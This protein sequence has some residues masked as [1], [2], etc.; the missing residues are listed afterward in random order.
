MAPTSFKIGYRRTGYL[1][2][3]VAILLNSGCLL[4]AAGAAGGAAATYSYCKGK[5]AEAYPASFED[6]CQAT[7][8]ALLELGMPVLDEKHKDTEGHIDSKTSDGDRVRITVESIQ[9]RIPAEGTLTR[10]SVRVATFGDHL[11]SDR[12]LQQVNLHLMPA[13]P[14]AQTAKGAAMP[15]SPIQQTGATQSAPPPQ[16]AQPLPASDGR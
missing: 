11:V 4:I 9:S 5:V 2:L 15:T 16:S 7:R 6:T 14:A 8:T 10:V 13:S 12:I 3:G 1:V